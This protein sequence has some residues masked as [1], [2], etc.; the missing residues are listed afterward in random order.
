MAHC[1]YASATPLCEKWPIASLSCKRT[2]TESGFWQRDP[3]SNLEVRG[4]PLP[5][6]NNWSRNEIERDSTVPKVIRRLVLLRF[7]I[8]KVV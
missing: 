2:E 6:A 1:N 5:A 3:H 4:K 7:E 8:A